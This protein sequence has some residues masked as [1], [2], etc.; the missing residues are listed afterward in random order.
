MAA[1]LFILK[2]TFLCLKV[3][4]R[5]FKQILRCLFM[6]FFKERIETYVHK[7]IFGIF[8]STNM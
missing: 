4:Y 1:F 8:I 5:K 2:I 7:M 6:S 3:E